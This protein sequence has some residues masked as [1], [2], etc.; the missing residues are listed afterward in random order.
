MKAE[1]LLIMPKTKKVVADVIALPDADMT[2]EAIAG[3][4]KKIPSG[5]RFAQTL[6]ENGCRVY[7]PSLIDRKDTWSG[8]LEHGCMTNQPHREFVYRMSYEMGRHIIGY[9]VQ[10]V[11]AVV[12]FIE[13]KQDNVPIGVCG[14]GEGGLIALY[15]G[16]VD[17]RVD[18]VAVGGYFDQREDV[19]KE[20]I[21]R[22][23]WGLLKE[24]GDAEIAGL[25]APRPLVINDVPGPKIEGPPPA[26]GGKRGAAP[27]GTLHRF[28]EESGAATEIERARKL[29]YRK[30]N[31]GEK[32]QLV[33]KDMNK[34]NPHRWLE[35]F[36]S[37]LK[38]AKANV[39]GPTEPLKDT[40]LEFDPQPRLKSQF[41]QAV[42]YTQ[43]L[44]PTAV[45]KRDAFWKEMDTS[46]I[47]K[48]KKSTQ[49][50]RDYFHE[51]VM[52]KLP[53]PNKDMNARTRLLY[54]TDKWKGYEVVLDLY[55]DVICYGILLVPKDIKPGEK[56]P[57]VVCQHGLEG[58]P[59]DVC[60]PKEDTRA[61]HSYGAKL[62]DQGFIVFAP[63]NPYIFRDAF[64]VLHRKGNPLKISIYSFIIQQHEQ[65]IN[66]LETLPF[67]D[68][69]RIAYY[70]LS[71][72]GKVAMR[73]GALVERYCA[74]ICSGDFN[75]WIWKNITLVWRNSYMYTGEYEMYE[76]DL[77]HTFNYAEMARLIAPRPFMVERGHDDGVGLDEW[78]A[79]EFARVRIL[80]SRLKI[81]E[82]T[83]IEYF[84]G[85]HEIHL[86]GTLRFL[87]QHLDWPA[88]R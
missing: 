37:S 50:Y 75:E 56:R 55:D 64:R 51:E 17:P 38:N 8:N 31:A 68:S 24:F 66:F 25:I 61:Y 58:R 42:N 39:T 43:N 59:Q 10:K 3:L 20:P 11:L 70:G 28:S 29:S 72:G 69:S 18:A 12:D 5:L 16:A 40:R 71:Y 32:I 44:L 74:V 9:E 26:V 54:E 15:A 7:I 1:G 36:L 48:F 83:E 85:V 76:F 23:V 79:H 73:I 87:R 63:Q 34:R 6:A 80:Y 13:S 67:V 65:I 33:S 82:K 22:N 77:G 27:G 4:D 45:K 53:A 86:V 81:P 57:V 62:A 52:G 78:V 47:A 14:Y 88:K 49:K 21:Y 35:M 84:A 19:W 60:N 41:D 2:P 46:S 30:L